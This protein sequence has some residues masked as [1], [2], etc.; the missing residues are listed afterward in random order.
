MALDYA[1]SKDVISKINKQHE[2]VLQADNSFLIK[3]IIS[4]LNHSK[5]FMKMILLCLLKGV[6][7]SLFADSGSKFK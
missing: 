7:A 4:Y 3:R 2:Q 6:R 1:A 5:S